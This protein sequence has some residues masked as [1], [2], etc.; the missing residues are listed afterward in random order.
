[1]DSLRVSRR[2]AKASL[3]RT[4]NW[5]SKNKDS[6]SE[7]NAFKVREEHLHNAFNSY[8][9]AQDQIELVDSD[10]T[11]NENRDEFEDK[12]FN[13]LAEIRNCIDSLSLLSTG[14]ATPE[15]AIVKKQH[16]ITQTVKLPEIN[17]PQFSGIISDWES[18]F[19]LFSALIIDNIGLSNI[20]KF[21][22]LKTFLKGEPLKLIEALTLT[23]DNFQIALDILANRY[24]NQFAIINSLVNSLIDLPN[25]PK[26]TA[27]TLRDFITCC[28][29]SLESLKNLKCLVEHW[30]LL[31]LNILERKLDFGTRKGFESERNLNNLPTINEFFKFLE[32]RCTVLENLNT[33]EATFHRP[34][35]RPL[36]PS[37]T[38]VK[39]SQKRSYFSGNVQTLPTSQANPLSVN[40]R[41]TFC[42]ENGHRIYSCQG[43]KDLSHHD[44]L[45]FIHSRQLC[46]NCLG[47]KH[48]T[49]SCQSQGC[50]VCSN[51]HHT[52]LH[53]PNYNTQISHANS[54]NTHSQSMSNISR[55]TTAPVSR[56]DQQIHS[57]QRQA[58]TLFPNQEA[59]RENNSQIINQDISCTPSPQTSHGCTSLSALS[60]KGCQVLLATATVTLYALDGTPVQAKLLLDSGSQTSFIT[61]HLMEKLHY[62]PYKRTLHISGITQ[63]A[64]MSN[65]ML[66]ICI[67]SNVEQGQ[68]IVVSCAVLDK[69]TSLLPQVEINPSLIRIP[70]HLTLADPTYYTPSDIDI[71][72]GADVYYDLIYPECFKLGKNLPHLQNTVLGWIIAGSIP[73]QPSIVSQATHTV[74][75]P[76][77]NCISLLSNVDLNN[78]LTKFWA[79]ED[80]PVMKPPTPDEQM[81]ED[82]FNTTTKVVKNG[83]FQVQLPFKSP[84]EIGKLGDSFNMVKNDSSILKG[85]FANFPN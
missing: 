52:L 48:A 71:L 27:I 77:E 30:D 74:L 72:L 8:S 10:N 12:Y 50:S 5:L 66:D 17:I 37:P 19:Q 54:T 55:N 78:T 13:A 67:F 44:K 79:I 35:Q 26:C 59:H 24:Q 83:R 84:N 39:T 43:F 25:L 40:K 32:K 69:I 81:A 34:N 20:Q 58:N 76:S 21:I 41:C 82:I 9:I 7:I 38:Q 6:E 23:H 70:N 49:S 63:N 62:T 85:G 61:T 80:T 47:T 33:S 2:S 29:R 51:R 75:T 3:T 1:M 36:M 28:T 18:F 65:K 60:T 11:D 42:S 16:A 57:R 68:R 14:G 45:K 22:Y 56:N 53:I 31:L 73:H 4:T 15:S 46:T 64:A